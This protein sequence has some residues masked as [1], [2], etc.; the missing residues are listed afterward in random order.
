MDQAGMTLMQQFPKFWV[1][2]F[3]FYVS[4]ATFFFSEFYRALGQGMSYILLKLIHY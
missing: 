1:L 4:E 3:Q 2:D